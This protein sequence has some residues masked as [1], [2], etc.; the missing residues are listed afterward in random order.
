MAEQRTQ[1]EMK[2][3]SALE[4]AKVILDGTLDNQR[5][6]AQHFP[7][8]TIMVSKSGKAALNVFKGLPGDLSARKFENALV[9]QLEKEENGVEERED[10]VVPTTKPAKPRPK[11]KRP[12]EEPEDEPEEDEVEEEEEEDED[13]E[14]EE[15]TPDYSTMSAMD[16][17]KLCIERGIE[18]KKRCKAKTY[19]EMLEK[20]DEENAK[21]EDEDEDEE[22]EV[23]EEEE[24]EDDD[25]DDDWDI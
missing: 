17:Y 22:D 25:D 8:M 9:K 6:V 23:E 3:C 19:I 13:E 2:N 18:A 7:F 11:R 16:L 24:G 15:E 1:H 12:K 5:Y 10:E 14:E 21:D 20:W 4:A